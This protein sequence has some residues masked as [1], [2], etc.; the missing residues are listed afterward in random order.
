MNLLLFYLTFSTLDAQKVEFFW[1]ICFDFDFVRSSEAVLKLL[2]WLLCVIS[3]HRLEVFL[4]IEQVDGTELVTEEPA[5]V[6]K[7]ISLSSFV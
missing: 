6:K 7:Q 4:I 5:Q 3:K 2:A 1:P